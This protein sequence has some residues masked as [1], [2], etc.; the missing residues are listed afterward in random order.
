M[1]IIIVI[2]NIESEKGG[3]VYIAKYIVTLSTGIS[4]F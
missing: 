1:I 3:Q 4:G 2:E